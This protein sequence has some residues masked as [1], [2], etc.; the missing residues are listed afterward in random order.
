MLLSEHFFRATVLNI[1]YLGFERKMIGHMTY[2][3]FLPF[4]SGRKK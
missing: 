3:T 4:V 1:G 2:H